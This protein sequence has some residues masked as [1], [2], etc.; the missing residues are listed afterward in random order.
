MNNIKYN[1]FRLILLTTI[2]IILG[3]AVALA[4]NNSDSPSNDFVINNTDTTATHLNEIKLRLSGNL[5]T[6]TYIYGSNGIEPH[7]TPF[8]AYVG[9]NINLQIHKFNIP[10][11]FIISEQDRSFQQPFNQFGL[12]PTYKWVTAHAGFRNLSYSTYSLAGHTFLGAG[13]DLIPSKF[14]FSAMY[15][16]FTRATSID[17]I[18]NFIS[19]PAFERTGYAVKIGIGS[20]TKYFDLIVL[21]VSDNPNSL[22]YD[23]SS[24]L[25]TPAANLV[26][27]FKTAQRIGKKFALAAEY[28]ISIYT[29]DI[30]LNDVIFSNSADLQ[31]IQKALDGIIIVNSTTQLLSAGEMSLVFTEKNYSATI[32]YKRISP[33]YKSMG[34]YFFLS[35]IQ[36]LTLS[37]NFKTWKK[38]IYFNGS[39]GLQ[40]DNLS[41]SHSLTNSYVIGS[42]AVSI[43]PKPNYGMNLN[44]S[45]Y[46]TGQKAA[47]MQLNDTAK[48]ALISQNL[49]LMPRYSYISKKMI[50][51][52]VVV[53]SRQTLQDKN[54]FT[55]GLT[56]YNTKNLNISYN[57]TYLPYNGGLTLSYNSN[58]V[59]NSIND[60][61]FAGL[62]FG[63]NK[64]F[65][66]NI[67]NVYSNLTFNTTRLNGVASGKIKNVNLG[68][69]YTIKKQHKLSLSVATINFNSTSDNVTS[70]SEI[71]NNIT[72]TFI[73]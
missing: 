40:Q 55:A 33:E 18:D 25:I 43:N 73:F 53:V 15:G 45:N 42:I 37:T 71:T 72:Y 52:G 44:Y 48:I 62:S 66:K 31:K 57:F 12:S 16:R 13:I 61:R 58:I 36:N 1:I 7:R 4:E 39:I 5:Y 51:T 22:N 41:Q 49:T 27:G 34:A 63:L 50:H 47:L 46:S 14:R 19:D 24:F 38:K 70:Y 67:L 30:K 32:K 8:S 35:D 2:P 69:S 17:T 20:K 23:T 11:S 10:F 26:T 65:L 9:G 6:G 60:T 56:E 21:N 54:P 28:D 59:I 29:N 68:G 3:S 64:T